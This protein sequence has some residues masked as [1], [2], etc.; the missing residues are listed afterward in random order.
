MDTAT[1]TLL[2]VSGVRHLTPMITIFIQSISETQNLPIV[3]QNFADL[4]LGKP[5]RWFGERNQRDHWMKS[6]LKAP[7]ERKPLINQPI[8]LFSLLGKY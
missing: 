8:E 3:I 1:L 2:T 6:D 4:N 7:Q 5:A